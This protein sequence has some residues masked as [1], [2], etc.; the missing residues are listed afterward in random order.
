MSANPH[1]MQGDALIIVDVQNDFLPGGSLAV[2][3]GDIAASVVNDYIEKFVGLGLPVYATRDWHTPDHCS[4]QAQGG[5]WPSH[6]V[7]G[8]DGAAFAPALRLPQDATVI[9]K[10]SSRDKDA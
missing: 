6:C 8:T 7:A 3:E 4:F 1:P 9:S 2:P 5:I 10:G